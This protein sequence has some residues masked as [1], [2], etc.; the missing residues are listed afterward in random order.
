MVEAQLHVI[1]SGILK[2]PRCNPQPFSVVALCL[3]TSPISTPLFQSLKS[4]IQITVQTL[5]WLFPQN[6][7]AC[8][9]IYYTILYTQNMFV[10][11]LTCLRK[12]FQKECYPNSLSLYVVSQS[13][14]TSCMRQIIK[15]IHFCLS[16]VRSSSCWSDLLASAAPKGPASF[17]STEKGFK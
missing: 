3:N 8:M 15:I 4:Y 17:H 12:N 10:A 2:N 5:F 7:F 14:S 1:M 11:P 9:Q 16:L 13:A 6:V